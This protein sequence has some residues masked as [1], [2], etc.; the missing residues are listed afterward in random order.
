MECRWI[1]DDRHGPARVER[2][3]LTITFQSLTGNSMVPCNS[4]IQVGG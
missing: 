4:I 1:H 3:G 2:P